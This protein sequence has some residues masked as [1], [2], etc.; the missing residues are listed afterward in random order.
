MSRARLAPRRPHLA[1]GPEVPIAPSLTAAKRVRAR[2]RMASNAAVKATAGQVLHHKGEPAFTQFSAS[3]GGW[4]MQ[5]T[6][7]GVEVPYLPAKQDR[8]DGYAPW[9]VTLTGQDVTR[10]WSGLGTLQALNVVSRDGNGTWGGR[11]TK[12]KVVGSKSSTTVTGD[13]FRSYLGLRS[14]LFDPSVG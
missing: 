9:K 10:H 11:V 1:P 6:V 7:G 14:T 12:I 8:K 4:T 5:G 2:A 3:N 13:T